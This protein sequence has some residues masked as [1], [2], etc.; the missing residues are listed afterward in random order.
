MNKN[1]E[2]T[3]YT[4]H[5]KWVDWSKGKHAGGTE[6]TFILIR[7][8]ENMF[9]YTYGTKLTEED[10]LYYRK[11]LIK[12]FAREYD[13]NTN[14]LWNCIRNEY[15]S[16]CLEFKDARKLDIPQNV[17][18]YL[19]RQNEVYRTTFPE[20][21]NYVDGLKPWEEIDAY[22][23]DDTYTWLLAITHEELKCVIV[24]LEK[25]LKRKQEGDSVCGV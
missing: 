6:D 8:I 25:L 16:R 13:I 12:E 3:A 15:V 20:I 1:K 7:R 10:L 9:D 11:I 17:L 2:K 24:G 23:F 21:C 18:F 19:E 14:R 5:I 4:P 22:I